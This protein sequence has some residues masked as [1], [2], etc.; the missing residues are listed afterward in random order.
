MDADKVG[1]RGAEA[2]HITQ[3]LPDHQMHIQ[4]HIRVFPHGF[5][6]RDADGEIGDEKPVHH[7]EMEPV[8]FSFPDAV[9]LLPQAGKIRG[10]DG[11]R[12]HDHGRYLFPAAGSGG[13]LLSSRYFSIRANRSSC[14][15]RLRAD[16]IIDR[17][18]E[19]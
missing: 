10:E 15:A 17:R 8:G 5:Q 11:G 18:E 1:S 12:D 4:E 19:K 13:L 9:D 7:V 14:K 16:F 3:G 6:H 2:L